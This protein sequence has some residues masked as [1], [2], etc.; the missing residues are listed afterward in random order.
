MTLPGPDE[1]TSL[2]VSI[3][4]AGESGQ[5]LIAG[6][7]QFYIYHFSGLT[8]PQT[9]DYDLEPDGLY[10]P[11]PGLSSYWTEPDRHAL[12]I[13]AD[14]RAAG[15]ALINPASHQGAAIDY[16]MGE[17]FVMAGFRR[18]GVASRAFQQIVDMLP[19][20]WELA[21]MHSN[22]SAKAFWPR[23]IRSIPGAHAISCNEVGSADWNGPIWSFTA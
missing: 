14:G 19:G 7:T 17:F 21:I 18:T 10:S 2:T 16:N 13:R 5:A 9:P 20:R 23:A 3:E 12:V 22:E 6:M 4:P 8:P 1:P 15:F 11:F